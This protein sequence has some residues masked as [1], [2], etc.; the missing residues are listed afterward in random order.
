[1]LLNCIQYDGV[2]VAPTNKRENTSRLRMRLARTTRARP[3]TPRRNKVC[4]ERPAEAD[5]LHH[6]REDNQLAQ[7][8]DEG[9]LRALSAPQGNGAPTES[10]FERA[11]TC[12]DGACNKPLASQRKCCVRYAQ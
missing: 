8:P 2:L 11:V 3:P 6:T 12:V 10:M 1:M 9:T 7:Q 5:G 4:A